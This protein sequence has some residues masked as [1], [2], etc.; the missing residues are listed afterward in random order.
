L[1]SLF[2]NLGSAST[3]LLNRPLIATNKNSRATKNQFSVQGLA[4]KRKIKVRRTCWGR[5]FRL[6]SLFC[7]KKAFLLFRTSGRICLCHLFPTSK[8]LHFDSPIPWRWPTPTYWRATQF[9]WTRPTAELNEVLKARVQHI[10]V[11][12]TK[13][14]FLK[15]I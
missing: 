2:K 3:S 15:T 8:T 7:R 14:H 9:T 12:V 4:V 11:P 13:R 5:R 6:L 1:L 10:S